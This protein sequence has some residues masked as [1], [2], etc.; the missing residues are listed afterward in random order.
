MRPFSGPDAVP[1]RYV[2]LK[3]RLST[4]GNAAPRGDEGLF[5][6][7]ACAD[8]ECRSK[9]YTRKLDGTLVC[10]HCGELWPSEYRVQ[11]PNEYQHSPR[12]GIRDELITELVELDRIMRKARHWEL[13]AWLKVL[14]RSLDY[15]E[16]ATELKLEYPR[17]PFK[18]CPWRVRELRRDGRDAVT[19]EIERLELMA[20]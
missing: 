16:A 15:V 5:Y 4:A 8:P 17:A 19:I 14:L 18:W 11:L 2:E 7:K 10:Q 9:K 3:R 13:V 1:W 20:A 12:P 6:M